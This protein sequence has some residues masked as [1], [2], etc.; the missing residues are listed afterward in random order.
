MSNL[1][2]LSIGCASLCDS[3]F[4]L[5][6]KEVGNRSK[7]MHGQPGFRLYVVHQVGYG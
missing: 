3:P 4:D 5:E 6:K 7:S 1:N 2:V